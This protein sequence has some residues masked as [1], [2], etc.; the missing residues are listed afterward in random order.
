VKVQIKRQKMA[1]LPETDD[2]IAQWCKD[3]FVAKVSQ[4]SS[5][6]VV[7]VVFTMVTHVH[8]LLYHSTQ[9]S[10]HRFLILLCNL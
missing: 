5:L 10:I 3:A 9:V 6:V 8:K 2:G 4:I 7:I 1:D